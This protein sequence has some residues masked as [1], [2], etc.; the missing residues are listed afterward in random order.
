MSLSPVSVVANALRPAK[1]AATPPVAKA[2]VPDQAP[3]LLRG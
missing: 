2:T 3:G 1:S